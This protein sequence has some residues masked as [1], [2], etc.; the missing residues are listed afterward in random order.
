M[1]KIF[2]LHPFISH[3]SLKD[4]SH[5]FQK[6]TTNKLPPSDFITMVTYNCASRHLCGMNNP[7]V[8]SMSP[9]HHCLECKKAMCGALCGQLISEQSV[10]CI[11]PKEN[12]SD[13]GQLLFDSPS[14]LICRICIGKC[15]IAN[16]KLPAKVAGESSSAVS[17]LCV[18][19]MIPC[20]PTICLIFLLS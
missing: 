13:A 3:F 1:A 20:M 2:S 8:T 10:E 19:F 14:A 15:S 5:N 17:M 9:S 18:Y 12:L 4:Y 7:L 16:S 11:I 6:E